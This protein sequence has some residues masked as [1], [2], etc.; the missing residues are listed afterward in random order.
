MKLAVVGGCG[1]VGLITSVG[2]ALMGHQVHAVDIDES[3]VL[4]LSK[5]ISPVHE[6]G[7]DEAL[8]H[9]LREGNLTFTTDIESA[10]KGAEVVFV[11]VG[12]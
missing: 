5:G 7:L 8:S 12:L 9:S 1:Y 2:F 10:A 4:S 11:A 6:D 3:K